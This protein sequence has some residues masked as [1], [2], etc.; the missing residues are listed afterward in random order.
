MSQEH[1]NPPEIPEQLKELM[2]KSLEAIEK[3][4]RD[5]QALMFQLPKIDALLLRSELQ[6]A[7]RHPQ[8]DGP[9]STV[10]RRVA[11]AIYLALDDGAEIKELMG[12]DANPSWDQVHRQPPTE[13]VRSWVEIQ[14]AH[15]AMEAVLR[16]GVPIELNAKETEHFHVIRNALCWVLHHDEN[17]AVDAMLE[18]VFHEL[19]SRGLRPT[20]MPR[21]SQGGQA[22][23]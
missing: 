21:P 18:Y 19:D 5:R 20:L 16:K 13:K 4:G 2:Q 9:G 11:E 8:N 1:T 23:G 12:R 3:L 17:K 6:L 14:M 7:L 10:A 22:N 15:D